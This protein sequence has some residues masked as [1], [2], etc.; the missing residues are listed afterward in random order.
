MR[1]A[2]VILG[3]FCF[4]LV[5]VCVVVYQRA[6]A[7]DQQ[8]KVEAHVA[9]TATPVVLARP[10]DKWTISKSIDPLDNRS[11]ISVSNSELVIRCSPKF[12]GYVSPPLHNL[13]G[14]LETNSD[15]DQRIRFKI[16]GGPLKT[17]TWDVSTSFD[18]LFIPASTLRMIAHGNSEL[19]YEYEPEYV[20]PETTTVDISGLQE[21]LMTAGCKI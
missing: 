9:Q 12:E 19:M 1:I 16:D 3:A 8:E 4:V 5:C 6:S 10:T 21:A 18:S 20:Q 17:G 7:T 2:K 13:G 11:K 14:M 15:R